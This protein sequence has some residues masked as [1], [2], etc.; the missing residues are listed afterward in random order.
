MATNWVQV[1]SLPGASTWVPLCL[2]GRS[3]ASAGPRPQSSAPRP[4]TYFRVICRRGV[5][6]L[7]AGEAKGAEPSG[8]VENAAA[9]GGGGGQGFPLP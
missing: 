7:A 1:T 6:P 5:F 3:G 4:V 9:R 2:R 8:S